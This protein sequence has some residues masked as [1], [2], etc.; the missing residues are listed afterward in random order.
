V[1]DTLHYPLDTGSQPVSEPS[2][3]LAS[4]N[5]ATGEVLGYVSLM[6]PEELHATIEAAADA[7]RIWGQTS[8]ASRR[9]YL[10]RQG[11]TPGEAYVTEIFPSLAYLTWN[12]PFGIPFMQLAAA[13]AAGNSVVVKPS[14]FTPLVGQKI[15]TLCREADLPAGVVNVVHVRDEHAP[16]IVQH[17]LIDKIVFTGSVATGRKVMATAA[18]G[19]KDVVLELGGKDTAIVAYDADLDRADLR[20]G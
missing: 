12:Y 14:P 19:P 6:T 10:Q 18:A 1:T 11:K 16:L 2:N 8:H 13:L 7:A 5:P 20:F 17:S 3:R 9:A 4:S 15:A